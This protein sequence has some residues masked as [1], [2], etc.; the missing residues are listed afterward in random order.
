[1]Q[2]G[3]ISTMQQL[4]NRT[5]RGYFFA[6]APGIARDRCARRPSSATARL[7]FRQR[8]RN[9]A[10][11]AVLSIAVTVAFYWLIRVMKSFSIAVQ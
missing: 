8:V 9:V 4:R 6:P 2:H 3:S 10:A 5:A 1:M 7:R 11:A